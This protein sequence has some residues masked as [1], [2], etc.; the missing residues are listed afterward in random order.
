MQAD[1]DC[2]RLVLHH[3]GK[4]FALLH[5]LDFDIAEFQFF[6]HHLEVP[7]DD[8]RGDGHDLIGFGID[9]YEGFCLSPVSRYRVGKND[10][11]GTELLLL[12][13]A[14]LLQGGFLQHRVEHDIGFSVLLAHESESATVGDRVSVIIV[15]LDGKYRRVPAVAE[16]FQDVHRKVF[17]HFPCKSELR[18][19]FVRQFF[20]FKSYMFHI[21]I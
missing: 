3:K 8:L 2:Y 11:A 10:F 16:F 6:R 13:L 17:N 4:R 5:H 9:L 15:Y 21:L 7:G 20:K 14:V 12:F 18:E 1:A 19:S